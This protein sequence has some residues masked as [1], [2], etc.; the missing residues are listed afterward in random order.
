MDSETNYEIYTGNSYLRRKNLC[1]CYDYQN[2]DSFNHHFDKLVMDYGKI[3]I[4]NLIDKKKDQ[5]K[6]GNAF[7]NA[8]SL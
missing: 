1:Y 4:V 6:I 7:E 3:I 2:L 5:L 8:C